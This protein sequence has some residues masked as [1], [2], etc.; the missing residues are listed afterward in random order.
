MDWMLPRHEAVIWKISGSDF[1]RLREK[2]KNSETREK[3]GEMICRS[4]ISPSFEF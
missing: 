4:P 3:D 1:F 2:D